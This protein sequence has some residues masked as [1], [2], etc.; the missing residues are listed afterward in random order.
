MTSTPRRAVAIGTVTTLLVAGLAVIAPSPVLALSTDVLPPEAET[1][2]V[3]SDAFDPFLTSDSQRVTFTSTAADLVAG[4]TN[5]ASDIFQSTAE[6]GSS[7]PFSATPERVS[8]P[9]AAMPDVEANAASGSAVSSA[10][11]R[12]VAF[13]SEATNLVAGDS[14][15]G[16]VHLYVRDTTLGATLRVDSGSEPN[17]EVSSAD[18]SDDGRFVVFASTSGNLDRDASATESSHVFIAA[19]DANADGR[20]GDIEITEIGTFVDGEMVRTPAHSPVISGNAEQVYFIEGEDPEASGALWRYAPDAPAD[21]DTYSRLISSGVREPSVDATGFALAVIHD[22]ACGG[23]PAVFAL[24]VAGFVASYAAVAVGAVGADRRSG[25]IAD[26]EITADGHLVVW[27]STVPDFDFELGGVPATPLPEP[28]V[29]IQEPGWW[30]ASYG[31]LDQCA[32]IYAGTWTDAGVGTEVS[33][34]ATGRTIAFTAAD[35]GVVA[36]DTHRND[37]IAVTSTQGSLAIPQFMTGMNIA[38]IPLT[39][40][41]DYAAALANAPIHR[42]PIHRLPIH[43]L[44]IHRLPIHRLLVEDA[45]IHRLPIHRLPIHR[46]PIHRLDLPAGWTQVL[47][48][49]PF[50]TELTQSIALDEVLQWARDALVNGSTATAAERAAAEVILSLTLAD[51]DVSDSGLDALS[52]AS[53]VLGSAP[54]A[55]IPLGGSDDPSAAW[56]DA[57]LRQGLEYPIDPETVVA[58]LDSAGLEVNRI[59]LE[60]V[61]LRSL[62]V[63]DTLF[64]MLLMTDLFLARTPLGAL[65]VEAFEPDLQSALFG[66]TG[67]EGT[68]ANPTL[69]LLDT[70]TVADFAARAPAEATFGVLLMSLLDAASYPWEQISPSSLSPQLATE[71][72][73]TFPCEYTS[74]CRASVEYRF[75]FDPGPGE[76]TT[77]DDPLASITLPEGT[78]LNLLW[79]R[80]SGP[81]TVWTGEDN[82]IA[83]A[84]TQ[85]RKVSLPLGDTPAGTVVSFQAWH[86]NTNQAGYFSS[87]AELSVEGLTATAELGAANDLQTWDDAAGNL[88]DAN[89]RMLEEGKLRFETIAPAWLDNDDFTGAPIQGPANDTDY[90]RVKPAGPGERLVV[91]TNAMDGQLVMSLHAPEIPTTDLGVADITPAPATLVTEQSGSGG[92]PAEAG[93]DAA[94]SLPGTTVLDSAVLSGGGTASLEATT[95]PAG[96]DLILRVANATTAHSTSLYSLRVQYIDEAPEQYCAPWSPEFEMPD[97]YPAAV[98]DVITEETNTLYLID[99]SR[100]DAT[101]GPGSA[102]LVR[103][104]LARL[105]SEAEIAGTTVRGAVLSI[106][107]LGTSVDSAPLLA[108]PDAAPDGAPDGAPTEE[109]D[110][111]PLTEIGT[112]VETGEFA[113]DGAVGGPVALTSGIA[114]ADVEDSAITLARAELDDNPCSMPRRAALVSA[115]NDAIATAIS[116][117]RDQITSVVVIGGDDIIPFAPVAQ[118]TSQFTEASHSADLRLTETADG[119]CPEVETGEVDPCATPLSA[120]AAASVILTDDAYGLA[121]AYAS[122]GGHLYVPTVGLGRLVETPVD[123]SM[124][125]ERFVQT[126]GVLAAD[127]SLTGGY[128]AWAELPAL[129]DS[130]LDWRSSDVSLPSGE[131][132]TWT[133]SDL[134]AALF[135]DDPAATPRLVSVNTHADE[136]R[137]LPG[138]EG[139]DAG[140][141]ADADLFTVDDVPADADLSS[142]LLFMIGCHAANN[143]PSAYYGEDARDWVD[144]FSSAGGF[145]GNTGYG[146]ANNV[147]TALG[148][149]LLGIY[150]EWVGVTSESGA[151][152]AAAALTYAKQS[153]LGELG[154]YSGYDEKALMGAIY[155]GLP[156]YTFADSEKEMPLPAIPDTLTPVAENSEG[157]LTASLSLS[158]QFASETRT[159]DGVTS[160]VVTAYTG[161]LTDPDAPVVIPGQ[162]IVPRLVTRLSNVDAPS[163]QVPRGVLITALTSTT[164]TGVRPAVAAASVGVPAT[165]VTRAGAAFPSSYA[166]VSRQ[167]TPAGTVDLLVTT[168]AR[169]QVAGD[170]TGAIE[171]FTQMGLEVV[172]GEAD[173]T[174]TT[175][176]I[177][178]YVETP[179]E[180]RSGIAFRTDD[181]ADDPYTAYLL[182][183]PSG[184]AQ[185]QRFA[186]ERPSQAGREWWVNTPVDGPFRWMLQIV[187][188][189]GNVTTETERGRLSVAAAA[190]PTLPAPEPLTVTA[191]G[192]AQT[193]IEV[194]DASPLEPLTGTLTLRS[195]DGRALLQSPVVVETGA[196]GRTRALVSQKLDTPGSYTLDVSV[197]R[198]GS[199]TLLEIPVSVLTENTPPTASV[200]ITSSNEVI[201]PSSVL[202]AIA[203][204]ADVD[205]DDVHFTYDWWRNGILF[206]EFSSPT[207]D[208]ADPAEPAEPGDVYEVRATPT[209]GKSA[210]GYAAASVTVATVFAPARLTQQATVEDG[211]GYVEGEWSRSIVT[212]EYTC[213]S[214]VAVAT[215]PGTAV[216]SA[217]T[218]EAGIVVN[219]TMTDML[220]RTDSASLLVRVDRTNPMIEPTVTPA[221]VV[222][223]GTVSVAPNASDAGSGIADASCDEPATDVVGPQTVECRAI[224]NAGNAVIVQAPFTV[225]ASPVAGPSIVAHA[226]VGSKTYAEGTWTRGPV[227]VTFTCSSAVRVTK[228]SKPVVVTRETAAAGTVVT[229]TVVDS[230][231]R[232]SEASIVVKIDRTRPTLSPTVTP[233]PVLLGAL[234]QASAGARDAGSGVAW[235][236]CTR[237]LTFRVGKHVVLCAAVDEVGNAAIGVG[238]YTVTT[239]VVAA[240]DTKKKSG[241]R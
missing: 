69:P 11:G 41:T 183:Q 200:E 55:E 53:Y 205:G 83:Q 230:L 142:T 108:A 221:E 79:Q 163:N 229:G 175:A 193:S 106:D 153:Y 60:S 94:V 113:E 16:R 160:Q 61:A 159:I 123:I 188:A 186:V 169:V 146:L 8:V 192:F 86:S 70:A 56:R 14:T 141:F 21:R 212:V 85:G 19:L 31:S 168:P 196:D 184:S 165:S 107:T 54:V 121:N 122:M 117:H 129:V 71:T 33:V 143:L 126:G 173:S 43:R 136:T 227:R 6:Q 34:S 131:S 208:L 7:D 223:G 120:A 22:T 156:M 99:S 30:D 171:T 189:A 137:L 36:V 102:T 90:F 145:I 67:V 164:E 5:G 118:H 158:P 74:A 144:V 147:T 130:A 15:A 203:T 161:T 236:E 238:K 116:D 217:D 84:I 214:G 235:A 216:V 111:G 178:H 20:L 110:L 215:C 47:A 105:S 151:V 76:P 1:F 17:G 35:G 176:P 240:P 172:Y 91:S 149:R 140:T 100:F 199:C 65:R 179:T 157:L 134:A 57:A 207:L 68:L 218:G 119:P 78:E 209:D 23:N 80:G 25:A 109:G 28:T 95:T 220:G 48:D 232:T 12:Y 191:G 241:D 226:K 26:P 2:Q 125:V 98:S 82:R 155:Y 10:D 97:A 72:A 224:D 77:F 44:P 13:L 3:A 187:D 88:P 87:T 66:T 234:A 46:L 40:L 174:D 202:T 38:D 231:G 211:S 115:I 185:W 138:V 219:A 4:D 49:T 75:A 180:G 93:S 239:G 195:A 73:Q 170:G 89:A 42:L 124:A 52:L 24:E 222:V 96:D 104:Q 139:A 162:P 177:V 50:A 166:T 112:S 204:G 133:K 114:A 58:E 9:D 167:Q 201:S 233:S 154:V 101:Y 182:V 32:G 213:E 29:R 127:S 128:G 148:E 190:A 181:T 225:I 81:A 237:P 194:T 135:P 206:R 228:C 39:S 63:A 197:C 62:P 18:L 132:D 92:A 45:P 27:E 51:I 150:A 103:E 59:G 37:G 198:S 210:G 64:D 152:S